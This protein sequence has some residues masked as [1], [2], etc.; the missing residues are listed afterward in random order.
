[1]RLNRNWIYGFL[2]AIAT[3]LSYAPSWHGTPIWDDD[4]HITRPDLQSFN[5]LIRIWTELGATQQ[6]YP[7]VHTVFWVQHRLWAD[8]TLGYHLI[9]ILLHILSTLLLVRILRLLRIPGAWLAGI[10]WA[11]HPVQV[12][13]VAWITELKN[14]LSGVFFLSA[15]LYYL[16]FDG[17]R[18]KSHYAGALC[19]FILG[20]LSKSV[21]AML[22]VVLIALFWW[23]RGNIKWKRD[24][25]PLLPFFAIGIAA[26]LFTAWVERKFI[27]AEGGEFDFS[28]IER[29]LIAGRVVWFY[30]G[31]I[32]F[33][34]ELIFTYPRWNVHHAVWWQYL[35]PMAL[36]L[37]VVV[38]FAVRERTRAPMVVFVYFSAMLF[39]VMGFFN[40][41]PF[42]YSFV[43]DH[44]Q[45]LASIGP[46]VLISAIISR[47]SDFAQKR[48]IR[49]V[50][51]GILLVLVSILSI[52]TWKQS[53]MYS[54]AEAL[55]KTT[56]RKNPV[57]WM[58]YNN[59][60]LLKAEKGE[61]NEAIACYNKVLELKPNS[62]TALNNLGLALF[63]TGRTTEAIEKYRQAI[64]FNSSYSEAYNN[65]GNA[66]FQSGQPIEAIAAF[67]K[68]LEI[69]PDFTEALNNLGN[70]LMRDGQITAAIKRFSK[71]LEIN[72]D[73]AEAHNNLGNAFF[74][75]GR[76]ADA[77]NH[78]K[79][80]LK[81]NPGKITTLQNIAFALAQ[82]G[83]HTDALSY[84]QKALDLAMAS[85][86]EALL[87]EVAGNI[88]MLTR[89][90]GSK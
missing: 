26:G 67:K 19:L 74:R 73:F 68:A 25:V 14:V 6:Y 60:G 40:V 1:M 61:T 41:Y 70:A 35:F 17:D 16:K 48:N 88:E 45:Y 66:L 7:L 24:I 63:T 62:A 30:L 79:F 11:L 31:K 2:I 49:F 57:C 12:E 43:A 32:I 38:L 89:A 82:Q 54:H 39:P 33:P 37:L 56:I 29:C 65:L 22:P 51:S 3:L 71:A 8:A 83:S 58:A 47:A 15:A 28:I 84:M 34:A 86:N 5:G 85:G 53:E 90:I 87:K 18:I 20:L 69:N 13:S 23:Q 80:A 72:P 52:L 9:N 81:I 75:T 59:L 36:F 64:S 55:Y 50:G 21:I 77:I 78:Y 4:Q 76:L 46:V 10:L 42:R 44:F 27:G